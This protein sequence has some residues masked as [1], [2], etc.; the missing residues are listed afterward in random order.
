MLCL[1]YTYSVCLQI[2]HDYHIRT[3]FQ[4]P[5]I[6]AVITPRFSPSCS[7]EL[8]KGL[9]DLA[10]EFDLPIQSHI[11]EQQDEV[12]YTRSLFPD[13]RDCTSIFE[14]HGLISDK[15][16]VCVCV[17]VHTCMLVCVC[18]CIHVCTWMGGVGIHNTYGWMYIHL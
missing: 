18:A 2:R 1:H 16:C 12:E 15:V 10:Q 13:H 17:C 7:P 11:C 8:M 3:P 6:Q 9:A 5:R 14:T 4:N